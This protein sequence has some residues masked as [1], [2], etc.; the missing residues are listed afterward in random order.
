MRM[1]PE[2]VVTFLLAK[3]MLFCVESK[4]VCVTDLSLLIVF[5]QCQVRH[6]PSDR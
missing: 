6:S 3:H 4:S 5:L 2:M 1:K